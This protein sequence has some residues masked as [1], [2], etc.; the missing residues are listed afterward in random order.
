LVMVPLVTLVT[1]KTTSCFAGGF[2]AWM[3]MVAYGLVG[4]KST[5]RLR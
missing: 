1:M 5:L 4:N 3:V 2:A